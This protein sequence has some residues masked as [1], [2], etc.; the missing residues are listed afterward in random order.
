MGDFTMP[1]LGAD[2]ES[3][4]LSQWLV[5]P[6][7]PVTKGDII[8]VVETEKSDVEIEVFETGVV[9]ELL[10]E[11]GTEVAVGTPLAR[12]AEAGASPGDTR[13]ADA[14]TAEPAPPSEAP[15][16]SAD[17]PDLGVAIDPG[18]RS[19]HQEPAAASGGRGHRHASVVL[20]P[21]VR[22]LADER[23][24]DATA[25]AGTGPGGR[26]TRADVERAS[27]TDLLRPSREG[28]VAASPRARR[29][30]DAAGLDLPS[31]T[32]SGPGGAVIAR[33][34]TAAE[35]AGAPLARSAPSASPPSTAAASAAP[36]RKQSMR[37]AIARLMARANAEIPH[38]HVTSTI[39]LSTAMAWLDEHN[40]SVA[41]G[42]RIL[43]AAL[44]LRAVAV[45]AAEVGD[46]NG[47]WVDGRFEPAPSVDLGV[48][49]SLRGGGLVTPTIVGADQLALPEVMGALR[50]LVTRS[51]RGGLR[52]S[53]LH[54]ASI[55]VTNLGDQG[56]EEVIG[57]IQPPQVALVGVG[58]TTDRVLA[59]DGQA[60]VVPSTRL[61]V[62]GD[63]RASDGHAG[64]LLLAAIAKALQHPDD[65]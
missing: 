32:G 26:V 21:L 1:S 56:A 62:S 29:L 31:L 40:R 51:R 2:M 46:L 11:P 30:A 48:A 23:H 5:G 45:A 54:P 14:P 53:D 38:Y 63:H 10:V 25:I 15:P 57:V 3:G 50:G 36:D 64:S 16:P 20:S 7:D 61:T 39:D 43:P 9:A 41:P 28:R 52:G 17:Q 27:R 22:H 55:T 58:R 4:T 60:V 59:I 6:G 18:G 42:E 13:P 47:W 19:V 24:V 33:D 37:T 49:I 34:V 44:I 8:A 65:L 12:I 35:A